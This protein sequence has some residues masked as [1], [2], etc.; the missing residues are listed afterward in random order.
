MPKL[1][2]S[3]N[4]TGTPADALK[5]IGLAEVLRA[6]LEVGLKRADRRV[7]IQDCGSYYQLTLPSSIEPADIECLEHPFAAGRGKRLIKQSKEKDESRT[8][9]GFDYEE[10]QKRKAI[11][12]K[13]M[14]DLGAVG[15]KRYQANPQ[16]EEF[17]YIVS[18]PDEDLVLY[19]C[20]SHFKVDGAYNSLYRQWLGSDAR[21]FQANLALILEAFSSHPNAVDAAAERWDTLVKEGRL[22]GKSNVTLL[23]VVNPASGK[24][25]N[26]PKATGLGI[27]NLDGFWL[28]EYL[29]FVGFFTIA[30]PLMVQKSKDRKTYVLHPTRVDLDALRE[31]M[32]TFRASFYSST[33]V[34][35]DILAALQFTQ[36]LVKHI[37]AALES[38]GGNDPFL[39]LFGGA[40]KITDVGRGFDIA[41]YKDMGSAYATMNLATINLPNWLEPIASPE[42]AQ[43]TLAALQEQINVVRSIKSTKEDEGSEELELLRRY[44]DFLSGHDSERFFDFAAR[45]GDYYL[46]KRH[47]TQWSVQ[48]TTQGME[49]LMTQTKEKL[50]LSPILQ[51]EG[52]RAI[53]AA[54]RRATVIAQ[55]QAARESGYPFEVRY[56]LGQQLLRAAAY[57]EEFIAALSEF[58]QSYNAEN[59]RIAERVAKG[60]LANVPRN[61]RASVQTEHIQAIVSLVDEYSSSELICKMLVAYGYARDPHTPEDKAQTEA[62]SDTLEE[63]ASIEEGQ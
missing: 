30:A 47:R 32:K 2:Y 42:A 44:R 45:Y 49:Q 26:T 35:L 62:S 7:T 13:Q 39:A 34:K 19:A 18:P 28:T 55:Y 16:A 36:A 21:T 61:R 6:W 40:P 31:V 23:Q 58:L 41:F 25:G 1:F 5:A 52:F 48:L 56:G 10:Q 24:G 8:S 51:N 17:S 15:R 9:E 20:L 12:I 57:P 29:K 43:T 27:G 54:I 50:K 59:A 3:D 63:L 22:S 53:A 33:A 4:D 46:A 14:Q 11:Y 38:A 60:S 37:Q